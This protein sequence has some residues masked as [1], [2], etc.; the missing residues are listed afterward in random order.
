MLA[1]ALFSDVS[2]ALPPES[3][4]ASALPSPLS[5]DLAGPSSK[6]RVLDEYGSTVGGASGIP[7]TV[8][9][10]LAASSSSS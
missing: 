6:V 9:C 4:L 5:S 8:V 10:W 1:A 3:V 2:R 7:P